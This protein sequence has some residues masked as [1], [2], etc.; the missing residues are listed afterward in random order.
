[1]LHGVQLIVISTVTGVSR[2]C[3]STLIKELIIFSEPTKLAE[4][5]LVLLSPCMIWCDINLTSAYPHVYVHNPHLIHLR[6]YS[7]ESLLERVNTCGRVGHSSHEVG[8]SHKTHFKAAVSRQ[9]FVSD[10]SAAEVN[11]EL[12]A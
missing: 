7:A 12:S 2:H 3:I 8:P 4:F 1:V 5:L 11:D 10:T 9:C 6:R